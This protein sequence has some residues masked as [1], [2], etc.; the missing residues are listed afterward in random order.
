MMGILK[1]IYCGSV[2]EC[3]RSIYKLL[4]RNPKAKVLDL[5]CWN[6][7]LSL[8][9]AKRIG[10]KKVYG[11]EIVKEKI[12]EAKSKGVNAIQGD[13]NKKFPFKD[14]FFDVIIANQIIE[15]LYDTDNLAKEIKRILKPNGYAII[16]TNNLSS[17]HNIFALILGHQPF[18]SDVS[19]Y[20]HSLGKLFALWGEGGFKSFSH[21]RI[22]AYY[23]LKELFEYHGF[24]IEKIVGVGYYP[25]PV[26][27]SRL[28]SNI[29]PWH[30][31]YQTIKVEKL[32]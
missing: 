23:G 26:L 11:I 16:S 31:V 22:F 28:F 3:K 12:K 14:N 2:D 30:S 7:E 19:D 29:D 25:F 5:G 4:E 8:Q 27:I 13:L 15:H 17:W 10:T 6:G 21:L 24:K 1:K 32:K 20:N 9:V 18:P